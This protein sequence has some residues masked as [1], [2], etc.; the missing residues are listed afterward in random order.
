MKFVIAVVFLVTC[1]VF[2]QTSAVTPDELEILITHSRDCRAKTGATVEMMTMVVAGFF[3]EDPKIKA[4]LFCISKKL[5]FQTE[6]GEINFEP[7]TKRV[8]HILRDSEKTKIIIKKC[9]NKKFSPE[10]TAYH[11]LKCFTEVGKINLLTA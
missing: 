11:A 7:L 10:E 9:A 8:N 3:P 1:L 4:Q 6:E 5:H 2:L